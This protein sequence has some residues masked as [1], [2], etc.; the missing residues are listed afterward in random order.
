[1]KKEKET[2]SQTIDFFFFFFFARSV[3][4]Q[5]I[6]KTSLYITEKKEEKKRVLD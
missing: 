4:S 6:G 5:N 1:V 2:L 3:H